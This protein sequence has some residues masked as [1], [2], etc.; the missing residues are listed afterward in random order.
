MD[1]KLVYVIIVKRQIESA[2]LVIGCG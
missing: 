1:E 2:H